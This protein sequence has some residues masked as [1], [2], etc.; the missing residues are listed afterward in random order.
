[1]PASPCTAMSHSSRAQ[2]SC[3]HQSPDERQGPAAQRISPC[4]SLCLGQLMDAGLP[5]CKVT[6]TS[7]G[8]RKMRSAVTRSSELSLLNPPP[9]HGGTEK[10]N[11]DIG[12]EKC[13]L[14][15]S[16]PPCLRGENG[17]LG[18]KRCMR[19]PSGR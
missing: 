18:T 11:E 17:S 14:F 5:S 19:K 8:G 16:V 1:M 2:P 7:T 12:A 3:S 13:R 4:I 6:A 9:R 10:F 15:F